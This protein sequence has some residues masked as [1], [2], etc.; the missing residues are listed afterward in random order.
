MFMRVLCTNEPQNGAFKC[1]FHFL[2]IQH[3]ESLHV[4]FV[5]VLYTLGLLPSTSSKGQTSRKAGT[6]SQGPVGFARSEA[7]LPKGYWLV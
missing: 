5:G 7:W 6:Q 2:R 4:V 3:D 1:V